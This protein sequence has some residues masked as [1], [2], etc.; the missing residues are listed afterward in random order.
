MFNVWS[1]YNSYISVYQN[2][3]FLLKHKFPLFRFYKIRIRILGKI[4]RWFFYT[5][6]LNLRLNH[7]HTTTFVFLKNTFLKVPFGKYNNYLIFT[8]HACDIRIRK[9]LSFTRLNNI[10]TKRGLFLY[11]IYKQKLGKVS[12][13]V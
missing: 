9:F 12:S 2:Y 7:S 1:C 6:K 3:C 4:F 11:F 10:F 5:H 13:Y 8:R